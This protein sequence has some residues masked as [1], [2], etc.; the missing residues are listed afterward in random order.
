MPN[1]PAP[2][3]RSVMAADGVAIATYE[4]G[5]PDA[6]TVLLVHGFASSGL[7]NWN[8]TGWV[9]DLLRAGRHVIA[10]DQRGHGASDKPHDPASYT[11]QILADDVLAVLDTFLLD[12]VQY[13]GYSL[14]ARVGWKAARE[15]PERITTAVLGGIP[16]GDP[17]TRFQLDEA[18]RFIAG[19][20]APDD[21]L[22]A[23]YLQMAAGIPNND[24]A[25][26][27]S[28]VEGMRDGE[29]PTVDNAPSQPLLF[30]TGS[31]D[32]IIEKSRALCAASPDGTFFEIPDRNHF[33]APTSREFRAAAVAF[34]EAHPSDQ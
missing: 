34:L 2:Q 6:S 24:L 28:L 27:V 25:A 5:D 30:A 32:R 7:G 18:R 31:D 14:G 1:P 10:I 23:T 21:R 20:A 12:E 17:L 8:L 22:T 29:Q 13:V 4:F 33:N 11:M 3:P 15:Y 9:R 26:L 19:G 16:D